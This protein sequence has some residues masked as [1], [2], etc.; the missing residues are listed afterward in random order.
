MLSSHLPAKFALAVQI[1]VANLSGRLLYCGLRKEKRT[2]AQN[3]RSVVEYSVTSERRNALCAIT[4]KQ[5]CYS[6]LRLFEVLMC[7]HI[8]FVYIKSNVWF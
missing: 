3:Q 7:K 8:P 4:K 1:Q 5:H 6:Q 2:T